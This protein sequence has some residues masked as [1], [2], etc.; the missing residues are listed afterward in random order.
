MGTAQNADNQA[1]PR[2]L[3]DAR[4]L[5]ASPTTMT[6]AA[7][8]PESLHGAKIMSGGP[9]ASAVRPERPGRCGPSTK[10]LDERVSG[11]RGEPGGQADFD[12]ALS[13]RIEHGL[14]PF[15]RVDPTSC[16]ERLV[17]LRELLGGHRGRIGIQECGKNI[18][19]GLNRIVSTT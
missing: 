1:R 9:T 14:G 19:L 13:Q 10:S 5:M 6:L 16:H 11:C 18:G 7:L 12:P 15:Y 17:G 4:S 3:P 2:R 8:G